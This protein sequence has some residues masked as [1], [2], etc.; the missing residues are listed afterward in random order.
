MENGAFVRFFASANY[1]LAAIK[2]E[3]VVGM[4]MVI[5]LMLDVFFEIDVRNGDDEE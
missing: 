4:N 5:N 2:E 3:V 1:E